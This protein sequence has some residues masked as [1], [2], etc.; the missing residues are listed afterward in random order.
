[1]QSF[2]S[3]NLDRSLLQ[4]NKRS[5]VPVFSYVLLSSFFART[6]SSDVYVICQWTGFVDKRV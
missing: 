5:E 2:G 3:S 4:S 6:V 1:M